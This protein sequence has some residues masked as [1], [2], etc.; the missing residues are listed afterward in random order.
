METSIK[1]HRNEASSGVEELSG[2]ALSLVE[3][4]IAIA[5]GKRV[6]SPVDMSKV[7][8]HCEVSPE[9][10]T[11][12]GI[13]HQSKK[14]RMRRMPMEFKNSSSVWQRNMNHD[15]LELVLQEYRKRLAMDE[16]SNPLNTNVLSIYMD[17]IF[18]APDT[19]DHYLLLLQLLFKT[20]ANLKLTVSIYKSFIGQKRINLLGIEIGE[21]T[22]IIQPERVHALSLFPPPISIFERRHLMGSLRYISDY[23]PSLNLLLR[24]LD[25]QT[26]NVPATRAK[27]TPFIW[28][29]ELYQDFL[30]SREKTLSPEVLFYIASSMPLFVETDASEL[31]FGAF[32]VSESTEPSFVRPVAY[33]SKK[34]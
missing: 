6:F 4:V 21:G 20:L 22:K 10:R 1:T 34:W 18:L 27:T 5:E 25:S 29:N 17:D 9:S 16:P 23:L 31:G 28:T 12:F 3:D 14:L 30:T 19:E 26:G 11:Y 24:R 8:F 13:S 33:F 15:I 7:F 32:L 2:N